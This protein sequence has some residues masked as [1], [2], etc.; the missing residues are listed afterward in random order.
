M[1]SPLRNR[2]RVLRARG[3]ETG[4]VSVFAIIIAAVLMLVAGLCIEGG[5]VLNTRATMADEAEQAARAGA[6]QLAEGGV[7]DGGAVVL[8]SG[9]ATS[10][11]RSYLAASGESGGSQVEVT[12]QLVSVTVERDV[13]TTLLRLIGVSSIHVEVTGEARTAV[14]IYEEGM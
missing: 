10:A 7:R 12:A 4:S 2:V 9:A 11:A 14:G 5:R 6:Q 13:P 3:R 1:S 8:D